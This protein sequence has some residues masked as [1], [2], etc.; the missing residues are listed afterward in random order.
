MLGFLGS[1]LPI[2]F[3]SSNNGRGIV[4]IIERFVPSA[5]S[6]EE[7]KQKDKSLNAE[8]Q[9]D[10]RAM[11]F[12]SHDSWFDIL[13]D[14][15][16]RLVRPVITFGLVGVWFGWYEAP[17]LNLIHPFYITATQITLTFWFG[18]RFVTKDVLPAVQAWQDR[19]K[20]KE[21]EL[22]SDYEADDYDN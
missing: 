11:K 13:V 16:N 1:L 6:R 14:G 15:I 2:F 5:A 4:D 21:E 8:S 18:G 10:A 7:N 17:D 9:N 3:G 22:L 19:K 20:K 12:K